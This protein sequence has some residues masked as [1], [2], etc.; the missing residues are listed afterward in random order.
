MS[1]GQRRCHDNEQ[2]SNKIGPIGFKEKASCQLVDVPYYHIA[3]PAINDALHCVH[4]EKQEEARWGVAEEAQQGQ[5][6]RAEGF[7]PCSGELCLVEWLE[8]A[9][10]S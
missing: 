4:K 6:N 10:G 3:T 9:L 8:D 7:Q 5:D 1:T 2:Y